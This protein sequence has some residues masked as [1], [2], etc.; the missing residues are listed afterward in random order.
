MIAERDRARVIKRILKSFLEATILVEALVDVVRN[1]DAPDLKEEE[2]L[3]T[4]YVAFDSF[5]DV[6]KAAQSVILIVLTAKNR[7]R[8]EEDL[9]NLLASTSD[10]GSHE[11]T[12]VIRNLGDVAMSDLFGEKK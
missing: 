12:K 4:M 9:K 6:T 1:G 10:D 2:V 8:F 3:N 7:E 5:M 11:L